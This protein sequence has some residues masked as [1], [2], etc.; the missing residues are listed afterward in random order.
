M[1]KRS[2]SESSSSI[3]VDNIGQSTSSFG[4]KAEK[5]L[6]IRVI[7]KDSFD[8]IVNH[9]ETN[10]TLHYSEDDISPELTD[11]LLEKFDRDAVRTYK[12]QLH[13]DLPQRAQTF[14]Y[15]L[16][17]VVNNNYV[18]VEPSHVEEYIHDLMDN[19][20]KEAKFEDGTDLILMPCILM[21]AIGSESFAAYSDK[22]G[23]RG[24]EIIWILDEDKHKFDKRWKRGDIQLIANMIAAVQ[25]NL[26]TIQQIYPKRMLG[27]KF[28]ADCLYF[29]SAY[30][31]EDYLND[32]VESESPKSELVVHKFPAA[33]KEISL[34]IPADRKKIFMYLSALRKYALSLRPIYQD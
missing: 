28:D 6:N 15:K 12:P 5:F 26:S 4:K 14:L 11:L 1:P 21:L 25:T 23:R 7:E 16:G 9:G 10:K 19:V 33:N 24:T 18:Q 13:K 34:S 30:V 8:D 29:Y 3:T 27:I 22:E 20:L 17:T 2:R 32:L 31:T